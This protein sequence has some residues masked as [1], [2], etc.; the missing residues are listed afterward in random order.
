MQSLNITTVGTQEAFY[1]VGSSANFSLSG[2]FGG[3]SV[4]IEINLADSTANPLPDNWVALAD[5]NG[6]IAVD[7]TGVLGYT[8]EPLAPC[9]VRAVTT[10]GAGIDLTFNWKTV[11]FI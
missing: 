7:G 3:T 4:G 10:G 2:T 5:A 1:H 9:W 11:K 8:T 6:D